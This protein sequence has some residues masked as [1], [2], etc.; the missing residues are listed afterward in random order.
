MASETLLNESDF[1]SSASITKTV[2]KINQLYN[3]GKKDKIKSLISTLEG[4]LKDINSEECR[5]AI[6]I[7]SHLLDE[8]PEIISKKVKKSLKKLLKSENDETRLNAV[9]IYG[10][11]LLQRLHDNDELE[12]DE[13]DNFL[14]MLE[15]PID[16]VKYNLIFLLEELPDEYF[17]YLLTKLNLLLEFLEKYED[18]DVVDAL[19]NIIG[20]LWNRT[21]SIKISVYNKI[22]EILINSS[23]NNFKFNAI[24]DFL[25]NDIF[26]FKKFIED[27][28]YLDVEDIIKFNNNRG[29]LIKI[30]DIQKVAKEEGMSQKEVLKNFERIKSDNEIF[31]MVFLSKKKYFI[32]IEK[33]PLLDRLNKDKVKVSELINLFGPVEMDSIS[34]LSV[35]IKRLVKLKEIKGYLSKDYFYSYNY[36]K[37][38][39]LD[40]L[41]K[42]GQINLDEYARKIN[43]EFILKIVEDINRESKAIGIFSKNKSY[44]I[45]F[46]NILREIERECVKESWFDISIYEEKYIPSDFERIKKECI[47]NFFTKYHSGPIWLTNIGLTRLKAKLNQ[48][49]ILGYLD[50]KKISNEL[51]IPIEIFEEILNDWINSRPGIWDKSKK[52]YYL[53]SYLKKQISKIDK[54]LSKEEKDKK[55][56]EIA[57]ELN[58]E[59]EQLQ[60][61]LDEEVKEIINQI[62]NK[63]SIDINIYARNLGMKRDEFIK[64]VDN[65][66]I[67]YLIQGK[68]MIFDKKRIEK[69]RKDVMEGIINACNRQREVEVS[70]LAKRLKFPEFLILNMLKGLYKEGKIKGIL[71]DDNLFVTEYGIIKRL[72]ENQDIITMETLFPERELTEDEQKYVISLLEHEIE[73]GKL[74]GDYDEENREFRSDHGMIFKKYDEEKT[75]AETLMKIY[76]RYMQE[77]YDKI[78]DIFYYK[79]SINI[80]DIKRK[81]VIIKQITEQLSDWERFLR[82]AIGRA[83]LTFQSLEDAGDLT[84]G[85][86]L[87]I[88]EK[89]EKIDSEYILGEFNKWKNIILDIEKNVDQIA[90]LKRELKE[91]PD[92]ADEINAQLEEL[93]HQL[94]FDEDI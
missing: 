81:D 7:Y 91:H 40:D 53:T 75:D 26:E 46:K 71:I 94:H 42:K 80:G 27:H 84:F 16:A 78:K 20:K 28:P 85:D 23:N 59:P 4:Y 52:I 57:E 87:D 15:D 66:S 88:E 22:F 62:K 9:I 51:D 73:E 41:R 58:I 50:V 67:E 54:S 76:R 38:Q 36:L 19:L 12:E 30:Y 1:T 60:T 32:E 93:Y 5:D 61:K 13:F 47:K 64:F 65:L 14:N 2:K 68:D 39:L 8:F 34:L 43:Y 90:L 77:C 69:K 29:P 79:K 37:K 86:V 89:K 6:M 17:D 11:D 49:Q 10:R 83:E 25:S 82:D 45:S 56:V 24:M 35:L 31:R 70:W 55:I 74:I 72:Y 21:L 33:K 18:E 3:K 44:Y 92:K 48:S 63:P